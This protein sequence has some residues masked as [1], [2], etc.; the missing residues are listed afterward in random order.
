MV[1][2]IKNIEQAIGFP[3][4]ADSLAIIRRNAPECEGFFDLLLERDFE[5]Y[6]VAACDRAEDYVNE[7]L[8]KALWS[9]VLHHRFF[10]HWIE[11]I[12]LLCRL[13]GQLLNDS[14]ISLWLG[15]NRGCRRY[16][17]DNVPMRLVVTYAGRGTE[18]LPEE[19]VDREAYEAGLPNENILVKPNIR[20]WLEPWDVGIFKGG[21][22]GVLHRTPDEAIYQRTILLRI[23]HANYWDDITKE[24]YFEKQ[25]A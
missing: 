10:S 2:E 17:I 22:D 24:Y 18:W 6:G 21:K 16:H 23:D 20:Q 25:H 8:R 7:L 1:L 19:A 9:D 15:T 12:S 11:D 13:F 5:V 4:L 3:E 14:R